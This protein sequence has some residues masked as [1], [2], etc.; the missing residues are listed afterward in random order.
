MNSA[1]K[2]CRDRTWS[3]RAAG[4]VALACC[5]ACG[6]APNDASERGTVVAR[7]NGEDI[8]LEQI[9]ERMAQSRWTGEGPPDAARR[10]LLDTLVDE[11]L[12]MQKAI[13]EGL[14]RKP[15]TRLAIEQARKSLLARAAVEEISGSPQVSEKEARSYY[16]AHPDQFGNRKLFT[17]RRFVLEGAKLDERVKARLDLAKS[18]AEV[19][20]A[21]AAA[22]ISYVQAT[23][24]RSAETL[25]LPVLTRVGR[26]APGDI[27]LFEEGG[28]STLMQLLAS[29]PDPV[30][31]DLALP[32][33]RAHLLEVH[34]RQ[35]SDRV[36]KELRR[37]GRIEYMEQWAKAHDPTAVAES[38][39][40]A[41]EPPLQK[42]LQF[43]H[44]TAAR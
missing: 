18:P 11:Q 1:K 28:R 42:P 3:I 41:D 10:R 26:M 36:V 27:L 9:N 40:G 23:Q 31:F 24:T 8:T 17:F 43:Q 16:A 33:I 4:L 19:A 35:L 15:S 22:G 37:K 30:P 29:N 7:V 2:A 25:P 38:R 32:G 34:L 12:L 5:A 13:A 14:D 6:P 20:G 44:T 39:I 21:L